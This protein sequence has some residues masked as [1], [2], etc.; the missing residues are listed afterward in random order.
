[1]PRV[2]IEQGDSAIVRV[3]PRSDQRDIDGMI[4]I[5]RTYRQFILGACVLVP[6]HAKAPASTA[7][8]PPA[9]DIKHRSTLIE[10]MIMGTPS[11]QGAH[12]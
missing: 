9:V 12:G 8:S 4:H 2:S 3:N 11:A 1:M 10:L 7:P 5:L 6:V